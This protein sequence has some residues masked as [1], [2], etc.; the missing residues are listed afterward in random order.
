MLVTRFLLE[1]GL[2]PGQVKMAFYSPMT[3]TTKDNAGYDC[4]PYPPTEAMKAALEAAK[5]YPRIPE[6]YIK[7]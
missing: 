5:I 6:K 4:T 3:R 2:K 7:K 1:S